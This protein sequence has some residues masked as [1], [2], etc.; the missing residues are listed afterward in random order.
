M[1]IKFVSLIDTKDIHTFYVQSENE[2]IRLGNK[3]DD[4][5]NSLIDSFLSAYQKE[6]EVLSEGS[7]F[8]YENVESLRYQIH[9]TSL[10][11]GSSYIKSPDWLANKKAITNPKNTKCD[12][13]FAYSI[14]V[15]LSHQNNKNHPELVSNILEYRYKYN[16]IDINF[17]A[18][19]KGWKLFEKNNDT[20]ALNILQVPHNEK[21]IT[22]VYKSKHNHTPKN[23]VVLL[24]ITDG[25]KWH[26]T[27]LKVKKLMK[28]LFAIQKIYLD[29]LME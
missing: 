11:R 29:Y 5:V 16:F 24:M 3:I 7:N 15:S 23:Q 21:N 19:I 13:R 18:G 6:Q 12:F 17:P 20:I 27:A 1:H 25:E 9:K 4:S 2:E 14:I 8:V 26:Y 28:D 10:K 22:H